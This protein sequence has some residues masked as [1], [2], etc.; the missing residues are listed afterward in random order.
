MLFYINGF[1]ES[2]FVN[3][4]FIQP[5]IVKFFFEKSFPLDYNIRNKKKQ[6]KN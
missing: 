1:F 6:K 4:I 2:F 3:A 5:Y